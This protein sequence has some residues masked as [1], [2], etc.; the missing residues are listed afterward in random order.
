MPALVCPRVVQMATENYKCNAM[1]F[2]ISVSNLAI[3]LSD[4]SPGFD[5]FTS[6]LMHTGVTAVIPACPEEQTQVPWKRILSCWVVGTILLYTIG[7]T[8][9][10]VHRPVSN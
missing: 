2:L 1:F 6:H 9:I 8:V 5:I 10:V 3:K 4:W 7:Q